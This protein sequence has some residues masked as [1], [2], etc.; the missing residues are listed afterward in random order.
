MS[1]SVLE[2]KIDE[3]SIV[4]D[5]YK[6]QEDEKEILKLEKFVFANYFLKNIELLPTSQDS[7]SVKESNIETL[8]KVF[9][10]LN[11]TLISVLLC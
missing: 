5:E 10:A 11:E 9:P 8:K 4:I 3:I 1:L 6:E 7:T 2:Q